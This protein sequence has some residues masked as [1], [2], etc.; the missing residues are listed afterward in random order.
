[1]ERPRGSVETALHGLGILVWVEMGKGNRR[2][3]LREL[4][5]TGFE[6]RISAPISAKLNGRESL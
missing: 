4:N 5:E 3:N 2:N 1:M 6:W